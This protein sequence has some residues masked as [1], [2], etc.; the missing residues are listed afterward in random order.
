[1]KPKPPY[2]NLSFFHVNDKSFL[3]ILFDFYEIGDNISYDI[4]FNYSK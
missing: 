2:V 1:M 3:V 4:L